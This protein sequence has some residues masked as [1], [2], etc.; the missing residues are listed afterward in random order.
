MFCVAKFH[1]LDAAP[2]FPCLGATAAAE[3]TF[4]IRSLP[5]YSMS[6][7]TVFL[8]VV[9]LALAI[10][11]G[12]FFL[13]KRRGRSALAEITQAVSRASSDLSGASGFN[14]TAP[15]P[16]PSAAEE[17]RVFSAA[18]ME[19]K[20]ELA[21]A[22]LQALESR[23]KSMQGIYEDT[24]KGK[25]G[26]LEAF[27]DT[28]NAELIAIK[29]ILGGMGK[30]YPATKGYSV[31]GAGAKGSASARQKDISAQEV[32]KLIYRSQG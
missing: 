19:K 4:K 3:N 29:E 28:A 5:I 22:R 14:Y 9:I 2:Y 6:S 8:V 12:L 15:V 1:G 13:M 30:E 17:G 26:R 31:T 21:H 20:I 10:G 7:V 32:R 16:Q 25:V 18:P 24:L 27:R 23:V 11:N